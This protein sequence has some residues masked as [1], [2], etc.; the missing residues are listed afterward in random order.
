MT[1]DVI[2]DIRQ[3]L[4]F[5]LDDELFA[6]DISTVREVLDYTKITKIPGMPDFM[7]GVINLRGTVVPVIDMR[8]KFGMCRAERT[9]NSCIIIIEIFLNDGLTV[10]GVLVDSVQEVFELEPGMIEPPPKIGVRLNTEFIKGMGKKDE[11]FVIILDTNRIFSTEEMDILQSNS[12][13]E[14]L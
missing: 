14:L 8:M 2:T 10:M 3:Y 11:D 9:V 5:T 4:T 12:K 13:E 6:L 7:V 1:A